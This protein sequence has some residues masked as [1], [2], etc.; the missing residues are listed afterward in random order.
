MMESIANMMEFPELFLHMLHNGK[1]FYLQSHSVTCALYLGVTE[2]NIHKE[3][4]GL[5][6]YLCCK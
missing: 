1:L 3:M 5:S 4:S 6:T 2:A